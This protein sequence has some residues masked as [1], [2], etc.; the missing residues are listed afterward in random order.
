MSALV[1]GL[2]DGLMVAAPGHPVQDVFR[3]PH[4]WCEDERPEESDEFGKV[5]RDETDRSGGSAVVV[6]AAVRARTAD[7]ARENSDQRVREYQ[8][9]LHPGR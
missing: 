4:W 2:C 6:T 1:A 5:Q 7:V 3:V 8:Q 9:V